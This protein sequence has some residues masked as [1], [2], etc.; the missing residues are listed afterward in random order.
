MDS[1]KICSELKAKGFNV[2]LTN[3]FSYVIDKDRRFYVPVVS[4]EIS[5]ELISIVNTYGCMLVADTYVDTSGETTKY[6]V[7]HCI[8]PRD[9]KS[10]DWI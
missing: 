3:L 8:Y 7:K 5:C 10:F 1:K 6:S 9:M 2:E 4:G